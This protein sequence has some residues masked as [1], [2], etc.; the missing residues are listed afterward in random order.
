[1]IV[2]A[3]P[4]GVEVAD[5]DEPLVSDGAVFAGAWRPLIVSGKALIAGGGGCGGV[6]TGGGGAGGL[7]ATAGGEGAPGPTG[8]VASAASGTRRAPAAMTVNAPSLGFLAASAGSGARA[9]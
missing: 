4:P 9:G 2:P 1:L 5:G 3:V 8:P 7:G 6:A